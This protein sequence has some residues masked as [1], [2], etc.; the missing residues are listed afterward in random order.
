M[1][2]ELK[3]EQDIQYF[4]QI[5]SFLLKDLFASIRQIYTITYIQEF[6]RGILWC[7]VQNS[8]SGES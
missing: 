6:S 8:L 5:V 4:L 7:V 2:T 1:S 3:V